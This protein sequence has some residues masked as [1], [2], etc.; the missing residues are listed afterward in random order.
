MNKRGRIRNSLTLLLLTLT[1]VVG[2]AGPAA[3][4]ADEP[5]VSALLFYSPSCP[6]CHKVI[7]EELP[8]LVDEY[9]D[10]LQIAAVDTTTEGGR[11]LYLAAIERFQIPDQRRGV[12]TLIIGETVLVGSFEIPDQL[13]GL[14]EQHLAAGGV[15]WPDIPGF[16]PPPTPTPSPALAATSTVT[17]EVA[18]TASVTAEHA[19]ATRATTEPA[20]SL[21]PAASPD[22]APT[23]SC[24]AES[25]GGIS[26]ALDGE[27]PVGDSAQAGVLSKL[28]RDPVGNSLSI[29]VLCG[30]VLS[31]ASV[32]RGRANPWRAASPAGWRGWA[33]GGLAILGV[34]VSVYM[35]YVETAEVTAVCGPVGDCNTVQQS[36]YARLFGLIPVGLLGVLGFAAILI[37]W[38]FTQFGRGRIQELMS[39]AL[40]GMA[41]FGTAFSIYLTFLEPFV[42]GATCAW[43]L[44]SAVTMTLILIF[45]AQPGG[46][47]QHVGH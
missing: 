4:Q 38:A 36:E 14:I 9:G 13:P 23:S 37:A 21:T 8:P 25:S 42:I 7:N 1:V 41:L 24:P 35:A 19:L 40:F 17:G 29:V 31:I 28:R 15:G 26:L 43:C 44:A 2:L 20:P 10:Q 18:A 12:P 3:T 22:S 5:V 45:S 6:H 47:E 32:L 16:V 33:V 46:G 34:G 39:L 30:M 27:Q 11:D